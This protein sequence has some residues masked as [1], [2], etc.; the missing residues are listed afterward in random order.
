VT[1]RMIFVDGAM[2]Y[3]GVRDGRELVNAGLWLV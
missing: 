1:S 2:K 3:Q